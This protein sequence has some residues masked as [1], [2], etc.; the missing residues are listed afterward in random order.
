MFISMVIITFI[1][2]ISSFKNFLINDGGARKVFGEKEIGIMLNQI[3]GKTLSQS[4]KNRLSRDI[5]PK[6]K[7]IGECSAFVEFFRLEKNIANKLI[8]DDSTRKILNDSLSAK[9]SSILLFGS[10]AD[11]TFNKNSD[12]DIAVVFEE[13]VPYKEASLFR[14]RLMADLNSKVDLQVFEQMPLKIKKGIAKNH[15]ILFKSKSFDNT[16]FI[17][18]NINKYQEMNFRAKKLAL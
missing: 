12:I 18:K 13:G 2:V 1:M 15:K 16:N 6:L 7:F 3:E 11:G 4:E 8:I 10:F 14:K 9:I 5:R 17:M